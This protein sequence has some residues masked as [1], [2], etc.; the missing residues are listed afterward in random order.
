MGRIVTITAPYVGTKQTEKL[1]EALKAVRSGDSFIDISLHEVNEGWVMT[2]LVSSDRSCA[3][4]FDWL[5]KA[6]A[7]VISVT[8]N[9]ERVEKPPKVSVKG[10]PIW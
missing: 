4:I 6:G 1:M 3:A 2:V 5:K 9:E 7:G 10:P 8:D